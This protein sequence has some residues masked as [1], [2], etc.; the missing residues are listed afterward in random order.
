M[1]LT[2]DR[3]FCNRSLPDYAQGGQDC[4]LSSMAMI[5]KEFDFFLQPGEREDPGCNELSKGLAWL[6]HIVIHRNLG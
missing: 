4:E 5:L 2:E 6:L 1:I 3:C